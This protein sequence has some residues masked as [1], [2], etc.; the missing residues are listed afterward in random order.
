MISNIMDDVLWILY[1]VLVYTESRS[2]N[3]IHF[4]VR[5]TWLSCPVVHHVYS[6]CCGH[7]CRQWTLLA[8]FVTA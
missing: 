7:R 6:K 8:P 2:I 4:C 3:R 1:I 5:Y